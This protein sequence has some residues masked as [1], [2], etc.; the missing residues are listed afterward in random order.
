MTGVAEAEGALAEGASAVA[1]DSTAEERLKVGPPAGWVAEPATTRI[2]GTGVS[3]GG[4]GA[5]AA[6]TRKESQKSGTKGW[7][8]Q[9]EE[10]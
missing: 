7:S 6:L 4:G 5:E 3:E 2:F 1:R 8:S 10:V 9:R